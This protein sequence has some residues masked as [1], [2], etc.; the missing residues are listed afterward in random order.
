M[1]TVGS[2][3]IETVDAPVVLGDERLR[4]LYG[5]WREAHAHGLRAPGRAFVDPLRLRFMIGMIVLMDVQPEPL[6]FRYRLVG[7]E[8]VDHLGVELTGSWLD[9]HPDAGRIDQIAAALSLAWRGQ[10]AVRFTYK[11][12]SFKQAWACETL[13]LPLS[14]G[15]GEMP[16]LLAGQI[17]PKDMPRFRRGQ[18]D[19]AG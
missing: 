18:E 17:F 11:L 14:H 6:R 9:Q 16:L 5:L 19:E 15:D 12:S 13:I 8:V 3:K 7:T 2:T 1:L 4:R 10:R